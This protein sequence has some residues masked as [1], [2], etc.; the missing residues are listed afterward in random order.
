MHAIG[1]V[2][3]NSHGFYDVRRSELMRSSEE[4][5]KLLCFKRGGLPGWEK[6]AT[7]MWMRVMHTKIEQPLIETR[8][9]FDLLAGHYHKL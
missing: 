3:Y 5:F 8:T 7:V 9:C 4:L 1:Q 6:N 2:N